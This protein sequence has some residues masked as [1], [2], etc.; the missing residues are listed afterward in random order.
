MNPQRIHAVMS[1]RAKDPAAVALRLAT[2]LA[3]P[4]YAFAVA[5]RNARLDR[6]DPTPLGRP[7]VSVGN[8][9]TGGT[10]KTPVV[11]W[12]CRQLITAGRRPAVLLRGY[13]GGDEAAEHRAALGGDAVVE[14]DPDRIAA[15]GRVLESDPTV[16]SFVLDDGFQHR[17]ARRDLDLVLIDA[18]RPFGHDHLLP[19]GMLRE[20]VDA[21]ARADGVIVTR[22]ESADDPAI[23]AID[24]RITEAT[25][26]P[27]LAH[28]AF[29]WSALRDGSDERPV[30]DL[31]R[32]RVVGVTG[33]GNPE[34][35]AAALRR[36]AAAVLDHVVLDDHHDYAAGE[37]RDVIESAARSGAEAVV[38]TEK[39]H[40]KWRP[41]LDAWS[42]AVPVLRPVL[43][44]RFRDGEDA[45]RS[46]LDHL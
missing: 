38:I 7:T 13:R 24:Q 14:P 34:A 32:M 36:H 12:V 18:T 46:L 3:E 21:L 31:R 27:P 1:G 28:T 4:A 2:R 45:A 20:P 39:D 10:G 23:E 11:Q 44:L 5:R 16:T 25:G 40:V 22:C 42:P 43:D 35:F 15:A 9:T 8:L 19:R 29:A 41:H 37:V 33:I 6:R 17:R 26:R 30:D